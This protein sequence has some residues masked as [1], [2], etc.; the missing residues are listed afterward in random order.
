[1]SFLVERI[2]DTVQTAFANPAIGRA[3]LALVALVL[4]ALGIVLAL[5]LPA[6][7]GFLGG[8]L[9]GYAALVVFAF[10]GL[11]TSGR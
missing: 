3:V 10:A 8:L 1:M 4:V 2:S 11:L 7:W 9:Y 5:N 6:G